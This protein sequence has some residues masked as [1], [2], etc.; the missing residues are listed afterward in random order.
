MAGRRQPIQFIGKFVHLFVRRSDLA[1]ECVLFM[2][3]F[4]GGEFLVQ[5]EL[6]LDKRNHFV[7][8]GSSR[9]C[10]IFVGNRV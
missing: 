7:V 1:L 6:W 10:D 3:E 4:G 9:V 2:I 8:L 5:V